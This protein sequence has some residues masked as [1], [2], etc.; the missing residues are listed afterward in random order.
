MSAIS[1]PAL[2]FTPEMAL[3]QGACKVLAKPFARQDLL[4]LV[5]AVVGTK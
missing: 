2:G 5:R 3:R 4:D 1:I